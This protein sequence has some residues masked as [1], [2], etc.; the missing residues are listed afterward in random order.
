GRQHQH[1]R[2]ALVIGAAMSQPSELSTIDPG[3]LDLVL[4]G[5]SWAL[6]GR[7]ALAGVLDGAA[8]GLQNGRGPLKGALSGGILGV[9]QGAAGQIGA[10]GEQPQPQPAQ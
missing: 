10:G 8:Q 7:T 6:L 2:A 9:A 4:G 1:A 3:E 5:F